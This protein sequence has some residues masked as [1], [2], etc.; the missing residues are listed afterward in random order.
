MSSIISNILESITK[1][2]SKVAIIYQGTPYTYHALDLYSNKIA[3]YLSKNNVEH[4]SKV[5]F[6]MRRSFDMLATLLAIWKQGATYIPLDLKTPSM[7]IE[8]IINDIHPACIICDPSLLNKIIHRKELPILTLKDPAFIEC[9]ENY[10][11]QVQAKIAYMIY[12]SGS[13]GQPKGVMISHPNLVNHIFWLRDDFDFSSRDCFSFNSSM[14]FDFSV[15]CT[16]LPLV[17]GATIVI[18]TEIDMLDMAAYCQALEKYK[19]TF[20]KW[21]PSYLRLLTE[22]AEGHRPDLSS[23]RYIMI[24]GEEFLTSYAEKWFNLYP[25]HTLINEYGPT[26]TT[27]GITTHTFTEATLNKKYHTVPIGKPAMNSTFYVVDSKNNL[28]KEGKIGE[29][30]I[31]GDSVGLGYYKQP[32]LNTARFIDHPFDNKS[33][34]LYRTGDLVKKLE[35]GNYLY[36]S[37]ID[38]Q[39]K[40][41]GF[42]IELSEI[43]HHIL[44][45]NAISHAKIIIEK[46][47]FDYPQIHAYLVLK[48]NAS[49]QIDSLRKFL[50]ER[51]PNFM[52]PGHFSFVNEIPVNKNGKVDY[53]A[54]ESLTGKKK[55]PNKAW[56][57]PP[58][59]KEYIIALVRANTGIIQPDLNT[60]FFSLGLSSLFLSQLVNELNQHYF[61]K[62]RITDLFSYP[63]IEALTRYIN[64]GTH[65]KIKKEKESVDKLRMENSALEPIAIIAMDCRLPGAND[66]EELWELCKTGKESIEFFSPQENDPTHSSS[67]KKVYARGMIKDLEYF[68]A[69]FFDFTANDAHLSDPQ[70]RLLLESAWIAFEKAGYIPELDN[71]KV[72]IYVSMNDSTYVLNHHLIERLEPFFSDRFALQ[73]LMSPQCL[74]TKIAYSLNCTGPSMTIQT[75]CSASLVAV[76]LA[77]QQLSS[78]QCDI[79]LAGGVSLITP[80]EQPYTYQRG[81]IFSPTGHCHPFDAKAEGTVFSNGLGTVVLKRLK[82]AL[83][84]N[85]SIVCVIKGVSTNNDGCNKMSFAAPSVQGQLACILAAQQSA[86]VEANSIQYIEAH[87]TGTL[88]G[89]PIEMEALSKAFRKTSRAQQFCAVGSL[90][91]N[92]GH[93]HVAAGIAGLIKTALALQ[94]CQIPP[95]INMETPNPHIDWENSPFYVNQRLQYWAKDNT[96]RAGISAFGVGGTNAHVIVE[97]APSSLPTSSTKRSCMLLLSAKSQKALKRMQYNLIQFLKE[98]S[99]RGL[100]NNFLLDVAYTLQI[101]R[102]E[103]DYKTGISCSNI[104]EAIKALEENHHRNFFHHTNKSSNNPRIVF[105]FPGQGTE[106]VNLSRELYE[107]EPVYRQYLDTCLEMASMYMNCDLKSLIFPVTEIEIKYS[108]EKIH[109]TEYVHPL[110]FSVEYSLAQLLLFWG[111]KP[112]YLLGHSLGEY[113]AACLSG[114]FSLETAIEIV[115][116]RGKAIAQ[117]NKGAMLIVP[118][119]EKEANLYCNE[120]I[121]LAAINADELCVLSGTESAIE[122]VNQQLMKDK[123]NIVPLLRK[124]NCSYSFHSKLL[125]PAIAPFLVSLRTTKRQKPKI[126]YFSNLT[127]NLACESDVIVDSYWI[128]HMLNPV[129]FLSCAKQLASY[130][131]I[132]YIE[133]G[134]GHIL[135]SLITKQATDYIKTL[136][137]LQSYKQQKNNL[138]YQ[139]IE[140]ALKILWCHHYPINWKNYYRDEKRRRMVLPTYP[141]EKKRYWFDE[142]IQETE[143]KKITSYSLSTPLFYVPTWT[144]QSDPLTDKITLSLDK[145]K[146]IWIIFSDHSEICSQIILDLKAKQ[147]PVYIVEQGLH[148]TQINSHQFSIGK[149]KFGHYEKIIQEIV[150]SDINYY[151][152]IH[153][154]SMNQHKNFPEDHLDFY[155]NLYSGLFLTKAF[156]KKKKEALISCVIVTNQL[157]V[158]MGSENTT[159][160]ISSVL[161]LCRVLSLEN[162]HHRFSSIDIEHKLNSHLIQIYSRNIIHTALT[163]L[164]KNVPEEPYIAAYRYHYCWHPSYQAL[165]IPQEVKTDPRIV[166]PNGFYLITG[167][168]GAM[169]LTLAEWISSKAQTTILLLSRRSFPAEKEWDSWLERYGVQDDTSRIIQKLKNIL[170]RGS[171]IRVASGDISNFQ[172]MAVIVR[173]AIRTDGEIKGIFHLAGVPGKGLACLKDIANMQSVLSPKVQGMLVLSRLFKKKSLD[174][175]VCASSLT[176]IVGGVGQLDYCAANLFL[177]YFLSDKQ[178]PNCKQF[179]TINWNSWSSIGMATHLEKSKTHEKVYSENSV[180]PEEAIVL[181]ENAFKVKQKQIIISRYHPKAER[182]RIISAFANVQKKELLLTTKTTQISMEEKVKQIWQN[183]LGL[184]HIDQDE[185]FYSLGG[186]SLSAIQLLAKIDKQFNVDISLQ[187]FAHASTLASL[188]SFIETKPIRTLSSIVPLSNGETF[189]DNGP[190]VYFIHPL[191]GTVFCYLSLAPYLTKEGNYYAIQDPELAKGEELFRSITDMAENYAKEIEMHQNIG[192]ELILVGASFGGNIAIEMIAPL[193]AS[194]YSV[195]KIILIDSWANLDNKPVNKENKAN[196]L[197]SLDIIRDYYGVESQQYHFIN[198]RLLWL[199]SYTSSSIVEDIVLLTAKDLLPLY[200]NNS[201]KANGWAACCSKPIMRYEI[202]GSHDTM[203]EA[204]HLSEL[205]RLLSSLF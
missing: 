99:I 161:S 139:L 50:S 57:V 63:T 92:I 12:T 156:Y 74:A 146:P 172:Q 52:I 82:D 44:Q 65:L 190:I 9:S 115:C 106:Y 194:G 6:L 128:Q 121:Y 102:K 47:E 73:R 43:E 111:I 105:L 176:S 104:D 192:K 133:V 51:L 98:N 28:V 36:I 160:I 71:Y 159:P 97:E 151:A 120:E 155:T 100:Q 83:N 164:D 165:T 66:C 203:F 62:L 7:R 183:V 116:A 90:K 76:A 39:V 124:L 23:F 77:C 204:S 129:Q 130:P 179:L 119:A 138:Q 42:R 201:K 118:L 196:S 189:V 91:G 188:T 40:V 158:V 131:N 113:V 117:C 122:R 20:A 1:Y 112:D 175:L 162:S 70:H 186:D 134:P 11:L 135:S 4:G 17:V 87:G 53:K 168:L 171:R 49:V 178:F 25:S 143:S 58:T 89:D 108:E 123:E 152:I 170:A 195:R 114:V 16:L 54:L 75:A 60:P 86:G 84:D 88:I 33:G 3:N 126:P 101:G 157:Q 46:G 174:F 81:N 78:Y 15:A 45:N 144:R 185:T 127:G 202:N 153:F 166:K 200:K 27:V 167:G 34:K 198:K 199:R 141:F 132:I 24:A 8:Q 61:L 137:L 149:K 107:K 147:H 140:N 96:R 37:R 14:A 180:S 169:G 187:E 48:E 31:G 18:S 19:V 10:T 55:V 64:N 145:K 72:G 103:F 94:H 35:S 13:T 29:L 21:T 59:A 125:T 136:P 173:K 205:G 177:D 26:E 148:Y 182:K 32:N 69:Y 30:L 79:A 163:Y 68:D 41:N 2:P 80:Q 56:I 22:Y 93:T 142:I 150:E 110:L 5:I 95:S 191:G 109:Q 67:E 184:S 38:N 197:K 154:W 85:D 181:L 193:R